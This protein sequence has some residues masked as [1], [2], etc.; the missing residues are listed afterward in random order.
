MKMHSYFRE[1]LMHGVYKN[2]K[3]TRFVPSHLASYGITANDIVLPNITIRD[4]FT[5]I[6]QYAYFSFAPTLIYRD[7]YPRLQNQIRWRQLIENF[8][9]FVCA[10]IY[11]STIY[12]AMCIPELK[13]AVNNMTN[14]G[15]LIL[16]W[17]TSM[18]PG[19]LVFMVLYFGVMHAWFSIWAE[20]LRFADRR[21]Y[22]DWWNSKTVS[23]FY[24]RLNGNIYDW[25][26]TYIYL[27]L[28]RFIGIPKY[29]ARF[30]CHIISMLICHIVMDTSFGFLNPVWSVIVILPGLMILTRKFKGTNIYNVII[31]ML[32]IMANGIITVSYSLE[33]FDR[34]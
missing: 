32:L 11:V 5:E 19:T 18:L 31:W 28:M 34:E 8:L 21:I 29:L 2:S 4:L 27:D 9:N 23:K 13:H 25:L 10:I 6:T 14:I 22:G 24:R 7:K 3:L 30:A 17:I 33:Y 16:A 26:H 20:L 15:M 12:N 1:K